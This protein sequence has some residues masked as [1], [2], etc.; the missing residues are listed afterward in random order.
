MSIILKRG[1]DFLGALFLVIGFGGIVIGF[2]VL[3]WIRDSWYYNLSPIGNIIYS[4]VLV[5]G[6]IIIRS[7]TENN[8]SMRKQ[9]RP[10]ETDLNEPIATVAAKRKMSNKRKIIASMIVVLMI[11]LV[12]TTI[13]LIPSQPYVGGIDTIYTHK[14][15][16]LTTYTWTVTAIGGT[17]YILKSDVYVQLK[18]NGSSTFIIATESLTDASGTHGFKYTPAFSGNYLAAGDVF[19]L[20][21]DYLQGTTIIL[22]PPP[23][24]GQY[25]VLTV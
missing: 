3:L 21:K 4:V 14:N 23:A 12:S 22:V 11:G 24:T 18:G 16:T 8:N 7:N 20:S 9:A 15:S 2:T 17:N 13:Y 25:C 5:L 6:I 10:S 19:S 1:S